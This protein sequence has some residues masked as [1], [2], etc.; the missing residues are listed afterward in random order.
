MFGDFLNELISIGKIKIEIKDNKE[1]KE[2]D[3]EKEEK[4]EKE[5]NK[6]KEKNELDIYYSSYGYIKLENPDGGEN[7][8]IFKFSQ[9]KINCVPKNS[10]IGN[11]YYKSIRK[12]INIQIKTFFNERKTY[13]LEK[14]SIYS[15]LYSAI[16]KIFEQ[17][18]E[19]EENKSE[20]NIEHI[21]SKSQY[22]I[23]SCYKEIKELNISL[24]VYENEIKDNEILLYLPIKDL[25]FS[26][27]I[28]GSS[29]QISQ[30]GKIASKI[31]TDS[32]QY[33]LGDLYYS[34][35]RHYFEINLLTEPIAA[36]V[37]IGVATK[38][39][40]KDKYSYDVNNFYGLILSDM[41]LISSERGKQ[42]KKDY[43]KKE[44]FGINDIVGIFLEFKK[45]GVDVYFY[46]NKINLGLA[47]TKLNKEN[48][49]YP[50]VSLG[51]AGSKI[52][53]SNKIDFP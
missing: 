27:Y 35:G 6:Q 36:S 53:I 46:K 9:Y 15:P 50:A 7:S 33:V 17:K 18:K 40:Q 34:F 43:N 30:K 29:I 21:T 13:S 32:P 39:N 8:Q 28:K 23:F 51:I 1:D 47:Y 5:N 52:Q 4:D 45:E 38:R 49:Y 44:T 10:L 48:V 16:E 14:I 12:E 20:K 2:K 25:S 11:I 42:M 26:Q 22:R 37:I 24:Y 19:S 3:K 41:I 31:N